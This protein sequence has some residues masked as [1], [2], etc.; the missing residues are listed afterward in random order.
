MRYALLKHDVIK[1]GQLWK[2]T[3]SLLLPRFKVLRPIVEGNA[4]ETYVM[5]VHLENRYFEDHFNMNYV[6]VYFLTE[7]QKITSLKLMNNAGNFWLDE[8]YRYCQ[9]P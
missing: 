6:E 2:S 4:R 5:V 9:A 8:F 1:P 7:E 3:H